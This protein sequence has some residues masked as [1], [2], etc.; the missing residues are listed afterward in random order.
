MTLLILASSRLKDAT[1]RIV[2][3]AI[4][5][6]SERS[7]WRVSWS[8]PTERLRR[9]RSTPTADGHSIVAM[10]WA[11]ERQGLRSE[12]PTSD[13]QSQSNLECRLMLGIEKASLANRVN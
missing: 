8:F 3:L 5:T 11:I 7:W 1:I 10:S 13:L 9:L 2:V 4:L 6:V 12:E